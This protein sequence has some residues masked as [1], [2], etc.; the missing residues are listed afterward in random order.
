MEFV[1]FEN[2]DCRFIVAVFCGGLIGIEVL[3]VTDARPPE[4]ALAEISPVLD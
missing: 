3:V 2:S 1:T 4:V